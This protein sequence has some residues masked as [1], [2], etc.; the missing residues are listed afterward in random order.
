MSIPASAIVQVHPGVISAGGSALVMNGLVLTHDTRAPVGSVLNFANKDDVA[1]FFGPTSP[2]AN[3]A[4]IYFLGFTNATRRPGALLFAQYPEQAVAA[5]LRGGSL[6]ALK[7]AQLQA[8]SGTLTVEV[9]GAAKTSSAIDLSTATSFSN[10]ATLIADGFTS[11]VAVSYD[12]QLAAFVLSS[13][14]T[15]V[16][17]TIDYASGTLAAGLKLTSATGA[18]LSQG[19]AA[20]E[21][22]VSLPAI[23]QISQNWAGFMTMFEPDTDTK[24]AFATWTNAQDN[25]YAYIGWDTDAQATV[26]DSTECWGAQVKDAGY[27]GIVCVYK[28]IEHAAFLLGAIASID[29]DRSNGRITLAFKGQS[30]LTA[31]VTDATTASTLIANGYN[32]YGDYATA[33]DRFRF[34]YPG[35]ISGEFDWID[36]YVN[37]IW[38]N[39]A[40]QQALMTLLTNVPSVPYDTAGYT[41]IEQ[42]CM[43]PINAALNF[44]AVRA[45]V[46]L[47]ALQAAEVNNQAGVDISSTLQTRGWYLQIKDASAQ[48]RAARQSPSMTFWYMDGQAVQQLELASI[49]VQ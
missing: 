42:A 27:S 10:A 19:S 4:A 1:S 21:A 43:D 31:T 45:G 18:V 47:S 12:A 29:F 25:R 35:Q 9:D 2:E 14:T 41:L 6:A 39:S 46:T 8:L 17:S 44:G 24:L 48:V 15:G 30:G 40:F 49:A 23:A 20:G 34:L 32:F 3:V 36:S 33:N 38:L 22:D 5:Y 26:E 28:S 7:L 13:S 11:G 37:Q 16:A